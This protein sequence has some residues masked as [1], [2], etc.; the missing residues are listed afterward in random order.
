[1]GREIRRKR[2][3]GAIKKILPEIIL[4]LFSSLRVTIEQA[5]NN[6]DLQHGASLEHRHAPTALASRRADSARDRHPFRD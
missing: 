5:D 6:G 4:E 2:K 1:M 3:D